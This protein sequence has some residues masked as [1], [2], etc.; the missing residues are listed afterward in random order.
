MQEN[1]VRR[2]RLQDLMML[3]GVTVGSRFTEKEKEN[4][5]IALSQQVSEL[6]YEWRAQRQERQLGGGANLIAGEPRTAEAIYVT[7]YNTPAAALWPGTGYY[8]FHRDKNL[9]EERRQLAIRMAFCVFYCVLLFFL[10]RFT[11]DNGGWLRAAGILGLLG[12]VW[13][14]WHLL[15]RRG[16]RFNFTRN[17]ASI[18]CMLQLAS[19]HKERKKLA[20]VFL[21]SSGLG[22]WHTFRKEY[23]ELAGTVVFLDCIAGGEKLVAAHREPAGPEVK[24]LLAGLKDSPLR[25]QLID[26]GYDEERMTQNA[27]MYYPNMVCLS[28]GR[29]EKGEFVVKNTASKKDIQV[30]LERLAALAEALSGGYC[31]AHRV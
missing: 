1:E 7:D 22:G 17:S 20:F 16:S 31:G 9:Q 6:G 8:P 27:L 26:K 19:L 15:H 12:I 3:Y 28:A 10:G 5:V 30:N 29:I 2:K 21:D 13:A 14:V 11:L 24:Q 4:F 25:E 18:A 23:P